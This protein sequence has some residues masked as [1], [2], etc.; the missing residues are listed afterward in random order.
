MITEILLLWNKIIGPNTL[1]PQS[2]SVIKWTGAL[3]FVYG[4]ALLPFR[5]YNFKFI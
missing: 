1:S 5:T 2:V 3:G 4:S